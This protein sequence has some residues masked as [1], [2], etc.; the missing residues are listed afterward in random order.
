MIVYYSIHDIR[1][2]SDEKRD[3]DNGSGFRECDFCV[4]VEMRAQA[5]RVTG[6][7]WRQGTQRSIQTFFNVLLSPNFSNTRPSYDWIAFAQDCWNE[8]KTYEKE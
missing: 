8:H 6:G 4:R 7:T 2:N 5:G 3:D 1:F